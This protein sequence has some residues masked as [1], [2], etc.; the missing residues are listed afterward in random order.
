MI[1]SD[2][3]NR[4]VKRVKEI[5]GLCYKFTSPGTA[6]VPDRIVVYSG[7]VIFVELKKP[8]GYRFAKLQKYHRDEITKRGVESLLIKN[9]EEVDEFIE[10]IQKE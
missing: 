6:G 10:R 8:S 5:G 9:Y 4:L 2:V 7:R 3:E 1:E